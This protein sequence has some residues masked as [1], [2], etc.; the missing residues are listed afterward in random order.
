MWR[1]L[2]AWGIAGASEESRVI[3]DVFLGTGE[4]NVDR[5]PQKDERMARGVRES[6][7]ARSWAVEEMTS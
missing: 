1:I 5:L 7:A 3:S 4:R 2:T 6:S